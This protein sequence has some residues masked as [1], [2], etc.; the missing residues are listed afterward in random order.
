MKNLETIDKDML[1]WVQELIAHNIIFL[2]DIPR[3]FRQPHSSVY[4][5]AF[6]RSDSKG[7]V[8]RFIADLN[9]LCDDIMLLDADNNTEYT[10]DLLYVLENAL[11]LN[12][13]SGDDEFEYYKANLDKNLLHKLQTYGERNR[14]VLSAQL[15]EY[16]A[17][18]R[19]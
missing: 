13:L 6:R 15:G 19:K 16:F 7:T 1:I 14:T 4:V 2:S 12:N 18:K 8:K 5:N 17:E 9:I 3:S 10:D 11:T